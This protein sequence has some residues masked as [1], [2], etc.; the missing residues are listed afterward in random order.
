MDTAT[1]PKT[2]LL[3]PGTPEYDQWQRYL[4]PHPDRPAGPG[5]PWTRMTTVTK[6]LS[7]QANLNL[8]LQRQTLEGAFK[9][10]RVLDGLIPGDK[11]DLN[12]RVQMAHSAAGSKDAADRGTALHNLSADYD[13]GLPV[14]DEEGLA[15]YRAALASAGLRAVPGL[16]ERTVVIPGLDAGGANVAGIAGTFDRIY[17]TT[18]GKLIMGDLKTSGSDASWGMPEWEVQLGGYSMAKVMWDWKTRSFEPMPEID[19]KTGVLVQV[20]LKERY[21]AVYK[22]DLVTGRKSLDLCLQVRAWRKQAKAI[23]LL[24]VS[25]QSF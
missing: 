2:T 8:W 15:M 25:R 4:I 18:S 17:Q 23:K 21:W 7:D 24:T 22:V 14:D 6:V 9:D 12:A 11:D 3:P 5:K 10:P 19:M 20:N 16:I 13:A 1:A